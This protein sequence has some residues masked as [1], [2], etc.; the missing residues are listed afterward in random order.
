VVAEGDCISFTLRTRYLV[1]LKVAS[2][3][4]EQILVTLSVFYILAFKTLRFL[5][6][7]YK[8][9]CL[10]LGLNGSKFNFQLLAQ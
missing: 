4:R 6:E 10:H 8:S 5:A 2:T 7:S 9:Q 3:S 1:V